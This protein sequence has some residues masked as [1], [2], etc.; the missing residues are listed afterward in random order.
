[1]SKGRLANVIHAALYDVSHRYGDVGFVVAGANAFRSGTSNGT[2]RGSKIL[3]R[4]SNRASRK[5]GG[6]DQK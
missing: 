2:G 3:P 1:M 6:W 5:Q 4:S